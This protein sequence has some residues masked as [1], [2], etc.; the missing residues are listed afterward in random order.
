[1]RS[2][3]LV[4]IGFLALLPMQA[5]ADDAGPQA[6]VKAAVEGVIHVLKTRKSQAKLSTEDRDAIRKAVVG[7]F[8]FEEMAKRALGKPWKDMNDAQKSEFVVTFR[9]LLERSYGNR[10]SEY[11]D[12]KVEYSDPVVK[13]R[14]AEVD[15]EVIGADKSTPV[16]YW[17]V[18]KEVG[19]RVFDIQV[20]GIS[21]INTFRTDF[22]D[23]VH[24]NGIQG[25]LSQL[26]DRVA[27]L[28]EQDKSKG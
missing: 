11:H 5:M 27:G 18:H 23:S 21:M 6:V 2:K 7:Y 25:F 15:S 26:K 8:D 13:G 4:L 12:Q 22:N 20:E 1:M 16:R 3:L 9:E 19:W 10:L 28:R 24:K 14:I 17:L